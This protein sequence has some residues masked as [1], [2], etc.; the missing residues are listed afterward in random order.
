[1]TALRLP[2]GPL[3]SAKLHPPALPAQVARQQLRGLFESAGTARLI[4]VRAPAGFGKTTALAQYQALLATRGVATAWLTLDPADNDVSRFL[5]YLVGAV[6]Q[7]TQDDA[8][9]AGG[10]SPPDAGAPASDAALQA[11]DRLTA[12]DAPFA[13]FLDEFEAIQET[14]VIRLVRKI[15]EQLPRRGQLV[16]AARN[17]PDL[18]LGRLRASGQLLEVDTEGLRFSLEETAEFVRQQQDAPLPPGQLFSLHQKTEGWPAALRLASIAM[19]RGEPCDTF[20]ERFSGTDRALADYLADDVLDRQP[21]PVRDFLLRTAVLRH[22]SAPLC[23]ALVPGADSE[24]ILQALESA[25]ILLTRLERSDRWYRYHSLFAD[26]LRDRLQRE[27]PDEVPRMHAAASRWYEANGR[28]V[29]AID[30]A[31]EGGQHARA[32]ALLALHADDLLGQG[33]MRLLSRWFDALPEPLLRER[34]GLQLVRAWAMAFTRSPTEAI[35]ALD[36]IDTAAAADADIAA[37]LP[38]LRVVLLANMDEVEQ[39]CTVGEASLARLPT[40]NPFAD[41]VLTNTLAS[42][43][44][45]SGRQAEARQLLDHARAAQGREA[46]AFGMMYSESVEGIIDLM[47]GRLRQATARFHIAVTGTRRLPGN[48]ANSNAMASV[49]YA[50]A[51][52]EADELDAAAHLLNIYVPLIRDIAL[53]DQMILGHALLSRVLFHRGDV[54]QALQLLTELEYL[55]HRK[56]LPRVV[57]SARLER[58]RAL[59]LQ[60]NAQAAGMELDRA[61]TPALWARVDRMRLLAHD[62]E[63]PVLGRLRRLVAMGEAGAA[64]PGLE[65][66]IARA[67]AASRLRRAMKLQVLRGL[68]LARSGSEPAALAAIGEVLAQAAPEGFMRLLI[69]EGPAVGRLVQR[70]AQAPG[71]TPASP[72][73]ADYLDRL[74]RGFGP[75]PAEDEDSPPAGMTEPTGDPLTRGE[76]RVLQLVA[77][78]YSNNAMAEKLFVSGNT[79]RTHLRNINAKLGARSRTQ[80]VAIG[81]RMGLVR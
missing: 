5:Q 56:A 13:L 60:G 33:R 19:Q 65:R 36:R 81:R 10:E 41:N 8:S 39:A 80:A 74:L 23:D 29:P 47:E 3:M 20:I 62:L 35:A 71:R 70:Q 18:Q 46:S 66:E 24:A 43:Y 4:L 57:A 25:N 7:I 58:A 78:G 16:I 52:Y 45:M 17:L 76:I 12:F 53:P 55:G 1:M 31:L 48:H 59:L 32:L 54:D 22:L 64:L 73:F 38:A 27:M 49:L 68:A 37:Q 69:D 40:S 75:L 67:R 63:D 44:S 2:P 72:L 6:A 14:A 11:V 77:E 30:H 9:A 50:A 34:P 15:V 42:V 51:L 28:F 26:F 21:A 61:G 79:V